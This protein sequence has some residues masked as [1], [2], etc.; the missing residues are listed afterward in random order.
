MISYLKGKVINK[1]DAYLIVVVSGLGYKVYI[2]E[3]IYSETVIN[4]EIELYIYQHVREDAL[5]LFGFL[6]IDQL[7][8]FE[9]LISVSGIGPKSGLGVL[10]VGAPEFIRDSIASGDSDVLTKVSGI[11]KKT[12]ERV[13]MELGD[14]MAS[15]NLS[16]VKPGTS[17]SSSVDE[18]D[19]LVAL[20]Y[21]IIQAREAL[22]HVDP[23]IK[24]SG[25]RIKE[26][27][28]NI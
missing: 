21:S 10:A 12:A 4:D 13:V 11:G 19:A 28:K 26:A 2:N 14:K 8:L 6:S 22:K 15:I 24:E 18:I 20:G 1:G 9:L 7:E 27:L 17:S 5:S 25:A 23:S 3:T 16:G